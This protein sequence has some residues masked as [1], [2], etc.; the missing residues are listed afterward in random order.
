MNIDFLANHQHF[1]PQIAQWFYAEWSHLIP[2]VSREE[3]ERR[4]AERINTGRIPMALVCLQ[5]NELLG[6]ICLKEQDM[7]TRM[8]LTPWL[9]GLYVKTELMERLIYHGCCVS[10]MKKN[11]A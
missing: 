4:I 5:D 6:T 7:E 1:I 10:L 3:V 11:L 8:E 9:A 2:S